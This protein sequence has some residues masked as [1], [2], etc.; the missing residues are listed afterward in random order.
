MKTLI[1]I[2]FVFVFCFYL[3]VGEIDVVILEEDDELVEILFGWKIV[4]TVGPDCLKN[5]IISD[6][7]PRRRGCTAGKK[8]GVLKSTLLLLSDV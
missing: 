1:G 5:A 8:T 7:S 3:D 6:Q 4:T 2:Y